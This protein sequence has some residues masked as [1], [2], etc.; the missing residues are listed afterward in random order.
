MQNTKMYLFFCIF[1]LFDNILN[2]LKLNVKYNIFY[3]LIMYILIGY[4]YDF[5]I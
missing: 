4:F 3:F 2:T 1:N 5:I